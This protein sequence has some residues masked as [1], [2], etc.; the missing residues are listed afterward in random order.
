MLKFKK[1][2]DRTLIPHEIVLMIMSEM[3]Y[4]SLTLEQAIELLETNE[5]VNEQVSIRFKEEI[6]EEKARGKKLLLDRI[7]K[8]TQD[9]QAVQDKDFKKASSLTEWLSLKYGMTYKQY[10]NKSKTCREELRD[11]C[12]RDTGIE[13][14]SDQERQQAEEDMYALL[15][16]IGVPFGPMGE[17]LGIG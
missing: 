15:A 3:G 1:P 17:P 9:K 13:Y 7:A 10:R 12:T 2:E 11:E 16:D 14:F 4:G 5:Q 6:K 8:H